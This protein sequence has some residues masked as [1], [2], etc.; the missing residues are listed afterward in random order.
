MLVLA[1]HVQTIRMLDVCKYTILSFNLSLYLIISIFLSPSILPSIF[2][3]VDSA[4]TVWRAF[5]TEEW[6]WLHSA[7]V[8]I[9]ENQTK[10][11]HDDRDTLGFEICFDNF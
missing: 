2:F 1:I 3:T 6:M 11:T 4:M 9:P 10:C 5:S 7:E 8:L